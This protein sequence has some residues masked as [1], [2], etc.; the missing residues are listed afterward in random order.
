MNILITGAS[1]QVGGALRELLADEHVL[2]CP[3]REEMDMQD[4]RA[5]RLFVSATRPDVLINCAAFTAVDAAEDAPAQVMRINAQAPGIMAAEMEKLGGAFIQCSTD[6]VF[7]GQQDRPYREDD[8]PAPLSIYG[9]SKLEGERAV[10]EE[11][12]A[13]LVFRLSWVYSRDGRNFLN[14]M[15]QLGRERSDL[16]VVDDQIGAPTSAQRIARSLQAILEAAQ[17]SSDSIAAYLAQRRGCY[18]L[19]AGGATSWYGYAQLILQQVA[20]RDPSL[21]ANLHPI[22]SQSRPSRAPRPLNSRLDCTKLFEVFGLS[23]PPWQEDVL[24]CLGTIPSSPGR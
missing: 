16:Y 23:L 22:P 3:S 17:R 8:P 1:G 13:A 10:L 21:L 4:E 2:A 20:L 14:T 12:G 5:L 18:H 24:A 15:L 19:C 11:C 6:Y 9:K 7:D